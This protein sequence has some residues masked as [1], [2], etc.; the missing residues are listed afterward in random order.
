[1]G[2]IIIIFFKPRVMRKNEIP[3]E[4]YVTAKHIEPELWSRELR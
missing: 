4:P 3:T 1:M 2:A